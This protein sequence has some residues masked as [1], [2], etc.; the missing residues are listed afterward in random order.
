MH[1]TPAVHAWDKQKAGRAGLLVWALVLGNGQD[2]GDFSAAMQAGH[3]TE[4]SI[5]AE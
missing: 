2:A 4:N 5:V 3:L 1:K